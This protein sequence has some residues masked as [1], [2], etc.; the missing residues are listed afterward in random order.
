MVSRGGSQC[1]YQGGSGRVPG[2]WRRDAGSAPGAARC[3]GWRPTCRSGCSATTPPAPRRRSPPRRRPA[4]P[5]AE[6]T[7]TQRGGRATAGQRAETNLAPFK[8]TRL[9][10]NERGGA[11]A[12]EVAGSIPPGALTLT[13]HG[14]LAVC[15][16][17]S[18]WECV[19]EWVN[20]RRYGKALW[21]KGTI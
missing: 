18:V 14:E 17:A 20:V 6:R 4:P 11:V 3:P 16:L 10:T 9:I 21:R 2:G 1:G 15:R 8:G 12:Q 7:T 13:A 19:R 5:H